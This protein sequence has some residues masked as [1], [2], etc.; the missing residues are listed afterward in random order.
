M[1][2]AFVREPEGGEAYG[3][4][5]DRN[6]SPHPNLVTPSGL[7]L[8]DRELASLQQQLAEAQAKDDAAEAARVSRDLRYWSHRRVTAEVIPPPS[9]RSQVRFGSRVTFEREDGSIQTYRI[10][11]E[12]EAD[13]TQGSIS[14]VSPLASA[15]IGKEVGDTVPLPHGEA[16]IIGID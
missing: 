12:D 11:G 13:P 16:E 3:D 1:S 6:V 4:L 5:P 14:Y 9:S 10:V 7:A 8:M 15:L 2:R